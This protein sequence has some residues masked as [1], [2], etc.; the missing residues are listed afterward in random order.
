MNET[1]K[2]RTAGVDIDAGNELVS[3]LRPHIAAGEQTLA[4]KGAALLSGLGGFAAALRPPANIKNPVLMASTDGV[5]TK[6]EL[7]T[8]HDRLETAGIDVVAM[9]VNDLL[10]GGAQPLFFLDY[11][12]CGKLSPT[13]AAR[14]VTGVAEGCRQANCALVGGETAEMPG[15]YDTD[16][17]DVA[18]FAVGMVDES[19]IIRPQAVQVGDALIAIASSGAHSN[20]Y[21]L[22]RH[23][24][25]QTPPIESEQKWLHE[26]LLY[27]TRIYCQSIGA[28]SAVCQLHGLA[29]ITGGGLVEN[30]PRTLPQ[31]TAAQVNTAA[32]PRSRL[33]NWL[34]TAGE[35]S[36]DE[37]WRVFNCGIGMVAVVAEKKSSLALSCLQENGETAWR[38]GTVVANSGKPH[39]LFES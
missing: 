23:I 11:Y 20:G 7:L 19:A 6:V 37:M 24:L 3:R 16:K 21:S 39:V 1:N 13:A 4:T 29:H 10:C 25:K 28:L 9:C 15:V 30:L 36:E 2:Y 12:A 34:K 35:I 27:P 18:G 8:Q 38:L 26:E 22:I 32:H 14:V 33:F 31:D 17:F 5:G